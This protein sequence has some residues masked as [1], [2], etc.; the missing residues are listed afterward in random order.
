VGVQVPAIWDA[1]VPLQRAVAKV[2]D[3]VAESALVEERELG[4]RVG[5]KRRLAATENDRPDEQL[6]LVNQ[7]GLESLCREVR[8]SHDK[9]ASGCGLQVVYRARGRSGVRAGCWR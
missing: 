3:A 8:T 4:T 2:Y 5:R 9:V 7:P 1:A 6:A